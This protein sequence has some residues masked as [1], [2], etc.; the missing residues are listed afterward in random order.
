M[1]TRF[2]RFGPLRERVLRRPRS[3]RGYLWGRIDSISF[4]PSCN[5]KSLSLFKMQWHG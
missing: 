4:H 2:Y 5:Y 3:R 1:L